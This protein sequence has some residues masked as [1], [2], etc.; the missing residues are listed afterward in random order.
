M[1]GLEKELEN[2]ARN[3]STLSK[4]G[5]EFAEQEDQIADQISTMKQRHANL[6]LTILSSFTFLFIFFLDSV[7]MRFVQRWRRERC[8][9]SRK[10]W[11]SL[12]LKFFLRK[13]S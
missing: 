6:L 10:K 12:R 3:V 4:S 2:V 8:R 5:D 1:S 7:R 11:T 13:P 9:N